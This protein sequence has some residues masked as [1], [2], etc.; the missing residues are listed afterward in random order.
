MA[1][2]YGEFKIIG[3]NLVY[4]KHCNFNLAILWITKELS[5]PLTVFE[6]IKK[7]GVKKLI[8]VNTNAESELSGLRWE[9]ETEWL[10][11]NKREKKMFQETQYYFPIGHK[12]PKKEK[13]SD[14]LK[15]NLQREETK[16]DA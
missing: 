6:D 12:L 1:I 14:T 3:E 5:I 4:V 11:E 13:K 10:E 15:N 9:F 7:R 2:N 8:F 16:H